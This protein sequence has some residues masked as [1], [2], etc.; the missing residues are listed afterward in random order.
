M[1]RNK[2][3]EKMHMSPIISIFACHLIM[4]LDDE[5]IGHEKPSGA[6]PKIKSMHK[7]I[8]K[9]FSGDKL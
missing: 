8:L 2:W 9:K 4:L 1:K 6:V 5:E 7:I 3:V